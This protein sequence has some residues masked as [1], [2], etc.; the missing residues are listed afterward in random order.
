MQLTVSQSIAAGATFDA[1]DGW[2]NQYPEVNGALKIVH[3]ATAVGVVCSIFSGNSSILQEA[4]V[5]AGGTAG[6]FP[7][8]FAVT[9]VVEKVAKG[10]R[11]SARY[12]NTT[13]A[14]ITINTTI[15]LITKRYA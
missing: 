14:A 7:S 12:R 9:P 11:L 10:K 13:G 8:E 1:L 6:Q 4:P 15:D 2:N 3:N 5:P